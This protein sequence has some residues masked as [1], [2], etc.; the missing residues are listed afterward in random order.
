MNSI[1][2]VS[3]PAAIPS[4][5]S[6]ICPQV[7]AKKSSLRIELPKDPKSPR[8]HSSY[9]ETL[10]SPHLSNNSLVSPFQKARN[11]ENI[12]NN[13]KKKQLSFTKC[14]APKNPKQ[15]L[16]KKVTPKVKKTEKR[17]LY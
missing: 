15:F 5:N 3:P 1:I 10:I 11:S 7:T 16:Q 17:I 12:I 14:I 13:A 2:T 4:L 9:L 6:S 8:A